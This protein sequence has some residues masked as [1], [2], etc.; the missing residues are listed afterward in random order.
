[1]NFMI[2]NQINKKNQIKN[3]SF[4]CVSFDKKKE[5]KED[6]AFKKIYFRFNFIRITKLVSI[7]LY[8]SFILIDMLI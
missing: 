3:V 2:F 1:M 4:L 6:K 8:M 5:D 7:F